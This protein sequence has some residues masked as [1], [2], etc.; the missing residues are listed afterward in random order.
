V[1][2]E[3]EFAQLEPL[4]AGRSLFRP[5]TVFNEN[6]S[7]PPQS[8]NRLKQSEQLCIALLHSAPVEPNPNRAAG[9]TKYPPWETVVT[10]ANS[11]NSMPS[12][13]ARWLNRGQGPRW[14]YCREEHEGQNVNRL[15]GVSFNP[16]ALKSLG[17]HALVSQLPLIPKVFE[18][19]STAPRDT[20]TNKFM[21]QS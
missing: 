3:P 1:N 20:W 12:S 4:G 2:P 18:I 14:P 15:R 17:E 7:P 5:H 10:I 16:C 13:A 21:S 19:C 8:V 6:Q 9:R 11:A